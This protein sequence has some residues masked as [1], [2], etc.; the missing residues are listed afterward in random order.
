MRLSPAIGSQR[1]NGNGVPPLE[2]VQPLKRP[3]SAPSTD[4]EYQIQTLPRNRRGKA[5]LRRP[6]QP[7]T[8]YNFYQVTNVIRVVYGESLG[9]L[10][11][12][13]QISSELKKSMAMAAASGKGG[14]IMSQERLNQE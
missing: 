3:S 7:K 11:V 2:D 13:T 9:R 14:R 5:G 4:Q 1:A 10:A 6:K 12:R 8:A